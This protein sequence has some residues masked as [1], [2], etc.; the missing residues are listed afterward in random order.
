MFEFVVIDDENSHLFP[1]EI[2]EKADHF[3]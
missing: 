1:E 2:L 3:F